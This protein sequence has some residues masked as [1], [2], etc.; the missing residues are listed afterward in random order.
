MHRVGYI[1]Y[2]RHVLF[3]PARTSTEILYCSMQKTTFFCL[4]IFEWSAIC[5]FDLAG[6]ALYAFNDAAFTEEDWEGIQRVGRSIKQDD[7]TKVGRFG[8]GFNS[9]YHITGKIGY[10]TRQA[11]NCL[12]ILRPA[13]MLLVA[14]GSVN[15]AI[16]QS[17]YFLNTYICNIM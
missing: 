6:P 3:L 4:I 12:R 10:I 8:I 15:I 5:N 17:M 2:G 9:V 13:T 7:P 14:L 16:C 11:H 1:Q